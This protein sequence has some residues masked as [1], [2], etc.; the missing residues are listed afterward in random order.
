MIKKNALKNAIFTGDVKKTELVFAISVML[1]LT[2][3]LKFV[4]TIALIMESA[5][6]TFVNVI[7]TTKELIVL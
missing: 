2:V 3:P 5:I 1:A 4:L 6:I 7:Q